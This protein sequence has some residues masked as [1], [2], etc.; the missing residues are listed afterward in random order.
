MVDLQEWIRTRAQRVRNPSRRKPDMETESNKADKLER[1]LQEDNHKTWGWVIYRC[2]YSSD[3][4][5]MDFMSRLNFHIQESLKLHN[6][7]DMM[8]SLDHH[9]LEDR[10]LFEAA[11]PITVREHFRQWVQDAPQREQG[12]PAMRSQRYNFCVHVDEEALQS[13]ISGPPPPAD[14]LGT[15]YVNLVCLEMLGGVRAESESGHT[16]LDRCWMRVTYQHLMPT[17]YNLFRTQGSW[18][19]EYREP[20]QVV[21]P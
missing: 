5:W 21:T 4:D 19:T 16:E 14:L 2:T 20:P 6:G 15:G 7:L 12:G 8:E 9:V 3:K 10:A 18:S 17:W 1:Q 11:N 13:V